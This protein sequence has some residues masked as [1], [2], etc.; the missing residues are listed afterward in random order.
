MP[1]FFNNVET[2]TGKNVISDEVQ[3]HASGTMKRRRAAGDPPNGLSHRQAITDGYND[4]GRGGI[5]RNGN[6]LARPLVAT[7]FNTALVHGYRGG[8]GIKIRINRRAFQYASTLVAQILNREIVRMQLPDINEKLEEF[9]GEITV[10]NIF[11][12]NYRPPD[13]LLIYPEPPNLIVLS[14]QDMDIGV[15]G[16]LE[17]SINIILP[18]Q[19]SGVIHVNF[20]HVSATVTVKL[21]RSPHGSPQVVVCGCDIKIPYADVCIQNGGFIGDIAN[22]FF[23]QQISGQVRAMAPNRICGMLP[24]LVNGMV[25]PMLARLPQSISFTQIANLFMGLLGGSI[26][27][28]CH[29]PLCQAR[30]AASKLPPDANG[31]AAPPPKNPPSPTF[32]GAAGGSKNSVVKVAASAAIQVVAPQVVQPK[33][34]N[35]VV[36]EEKKTQAFNGRS[37]IGGKNGSGKLISGNP[38]HYKQPTQVV[39]SSDAL[40]FARTKRETVK[41]ESLPSD[42]RNDIMDWSRSVQSM[43]QQ[44]TV[45]LHLPPRDLY[46]RQQDQ[47][48]LRQQQKQKATQKFAFQQSVFTEGG[49]RKVSTSA[50]HIRASSSSANQSNKSALA[51]HGVPVALPATKDYYRSGGFGGDV[52]GAVG[53]RGGIRDP[54]AG[55]P[56]T[57]SDSFGVIS[58]LIKQQLDMRKVANLVLTTQLLQACATHNDF[59]IDLNGEFS[60]GGRGGTPFRPFPMQWPTPVGSSMIEILISDFTIN[61]LLYWMHRA[62]FLSFRIGPETPSIGALLTTTCDIGDYSGEELENEALF[63]RLLR[64]S[65][66]RRRYSLFHQQRSKRQAITAGDSNLGNLGDLTDLGICLGDIIPAIKEEYPNRTLAL[67]IHSAR[68]PSILISIRKGGSVRLDLTAFV[69]IYLDRTNIRVGTMTVIAIAD[70]TLRIIGNR[71]I[72]NATLPVLRLL[73]RDQ[74]L[75]LQQD[76]LDNLA[77]LANDIILKAANQQF[78]RGMELSLPISSLPLNIVNPHIRILEHAIYISSDFTISPSAL[79]FLA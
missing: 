60:P 25:N 42:V 8:P 69:D 65:Q 58:S 35:N 13:C 21:E 47:Q 9:F 54:C 15:A 43:Q 10:C 41:F 48:R 12:S 75:G 49:S 44:Q 66:Q 1:T 24:Q 50:Y 33:F 68:A 57:A 16:N 6:L 72:A 46:Q 36:A 52:G 40:P 56:S 51:A 70:I 4:I 45:M 22:L 71:I 53:L 79:R 17:G 38:Q 39:L 73:D 19:L 3:K 61:S 31:I 2:H 62:N 30:L 37:A 77:S 59:T 23:R 32:S 67:L 14:L 26:P 7:D 55:C 20:Y 29:S 5:G 64:L 18:I 11:V 34:R 63:I 28:H 74:T 76:A 27:A 78:N